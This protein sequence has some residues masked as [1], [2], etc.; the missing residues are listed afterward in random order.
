[1][2]NVKSLFLTRE[3]KQRKLEERISGLSTDELKDVVDRYQDL[4][5]YSALSRVSLHFFEAFTGEGASLDE[6]TIARRVLEERKVVYYGR[7]F[8]SSSASQSRLTS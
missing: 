7:E 5:H 4:Q 2:A 6:Y 1:M 8:I 3:E